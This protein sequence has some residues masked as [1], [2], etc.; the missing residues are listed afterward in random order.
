MN[1]FFFHFFQFSHC[2]ILV[3]KYLL[4]KKHVFTVNR[5]KIFNIILLQNWLYASIYK[6]I[7]KS[8]SSKGFCSK[9]RARG[10][11]FLEKN[12]NSLTSKYTIQ[13][14]KTLLYSTFIIIQLCLNIF[15]LHNVFHI[16]TN[17]CLFALNKIKTTIILK[18]KHYNARLLF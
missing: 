6:S 13:C 16:C 9:F 4:F 1:K 3:K 15:K 12:S 10:Y 17:I 2:I 18:L 5:E 11:P 14:S 7:S 8:W